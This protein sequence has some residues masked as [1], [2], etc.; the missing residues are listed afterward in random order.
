M[1]LIENQTIRNQGIVIDDKE[2]RNCNL[3][4]CVLEYSGGPVVFKHSHMSGCRYVFFGPA[5]ATVHFL[6]AVG[7]TAGLSSDWAEIP[8]RVH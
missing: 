6:Q 2:F 8:D 5:R 7:L 4:D 1:E 3:I